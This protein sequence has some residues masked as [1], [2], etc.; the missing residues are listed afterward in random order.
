MSTEVIFRHLHV[1]E[2]NNEIHTQ[3]SRL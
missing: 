3:S 1:T 2:G